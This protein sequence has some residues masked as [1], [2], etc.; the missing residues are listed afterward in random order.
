MHTRTVF[1]AALVLGV[2][3]GVGTGYAV[4]AAR[5]A[6]PLPPLTATQPEY[7][8]A[9]VYQ[10]LAPA[11]LPS[12]Q[13][14]ATL[15]DGDLT[16]LLLPVPAGAKADPTGW[17]DQ[18]ID[19]EQEA[20]LCDNAVS[21]FRRD[22]S[23]NLNAIADTSWDQNGFYVEIRIYRFAAGSSGT[24]RSWSQ[25]GDRQTGE[26][27]IAPGIDGSGYEYRDKWGANDDTAEA[28]H[29]DLV[30]QFWVTS[31]TTMPNT[32]MINNLITQQMGR[33]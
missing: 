27:T 24:P 31:P 5:P 28:V 9:G 6:T 3:G 19:A 12:S 14:D 11:T 1:G 26:F 22:G 21:C 4:Q 2:L 17:Q 16:K 29:G 10:G 18:S 25:D 20:D 13:D 8:P 15:T 30:V 23:D 7:A 33:L 32:S